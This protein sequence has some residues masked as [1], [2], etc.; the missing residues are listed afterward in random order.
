MAEGILNI[1]CHSGVS[2]TNHGFPKCL[3][4]FAHSYSIYTSIFCENAR[5]SY[6]QVSG[7][8]HNKFS[9]SDIAY[10]HG[11]ALASGTFDRHRSSA[12]VSTEEDQV[13]AGFL[14]W[15]G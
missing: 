1:L 13:D 4:M 11:L 15:T 3:C 14:R 10:C 9:N 6:D 5:P 8:K 12:N 7:S 2:S